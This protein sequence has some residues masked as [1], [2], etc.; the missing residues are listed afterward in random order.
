MAGI[1]ATRA[2]GAV[3]EWRDAMRV[4]SW[5]TPDEAVAAGLADEAVDEVGTQDASA[6][7]DLRMYAFAH[8]GRAAAPAPV[9]PVRPEPPAPPPPTTAAEAARRIH[10]ASTKNTNKEGAGLM[11]PAKIREALGLAPDVS[12]D[13]V[14]AAAQAAFGLAAAPAAAAPAAP[15]PPATGQAPAT[16]TAAVPGTVVVSESMWAQTQEQ[17]RSLAAFVDKTKRDE[18]DTVIDQAI[19]DGKFTP[20][21]RDHFAKLWDSNPDGTRA[22]IDSMLRNSA[23]AVTALGHANGNDDEFE[24]EYQAL[25]A[26]LQ[27]WGR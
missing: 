24:R 14:R 7:F 25:V 11:D 10:A 3:A 23:F 27:K 17:L 22:V 6:R 20:A 1:Y 5:Y 19:R 16:P 4:E 2:G 8:A 15:T 9:L 13:E 21:Q 18:R 26:P 12:D